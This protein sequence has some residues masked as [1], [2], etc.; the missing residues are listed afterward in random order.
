MLF[1]STDK[2]LCIF[3]HVLMQMSVKMSK[4]RT[5]GWEDILM[6]PDLDEHDGTRYQETSSD[7]ENDNSDCNISMDEPI[8]IADNGLSHGVS[9]SRGA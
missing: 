6:A 3:P 9:R 1:E 8:M 5:L 4:N 2:F 7:E